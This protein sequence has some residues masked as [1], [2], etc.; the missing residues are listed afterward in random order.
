MISS[1]HH[2]TRWRRTQTQRPLYPKKIHFNTFILYVN[3]NL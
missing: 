3:T 2:I 1:S